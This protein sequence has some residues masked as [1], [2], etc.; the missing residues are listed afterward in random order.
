MSPLCAIIPARSSPLRIDRSNYK[1]VRYGWAK[2][3]SPYLYRKVRK[4]WPC[5]EIESV[6]K[7]VVDHECR[8]PALDAQQPKRR[9]SEPT[10]RARAARA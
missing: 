8:F 1:S 3:V 7:C 9:E 5:C 2:A 4:D 6:G 10:K